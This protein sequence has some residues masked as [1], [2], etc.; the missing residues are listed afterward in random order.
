MAVIVNISRN[1]NECQT[2]SGEVWHNIAVSSHKML[3]KHKKNVVILKG[4]KP[5][6]YHLDQVIKV[7]LSSDLMSERCKS[8]DFM[9]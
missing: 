6:R 8:P 1:I 2:W 4:E 5:S 3:I 7:S 9:H